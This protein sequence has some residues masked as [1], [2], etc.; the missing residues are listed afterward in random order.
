MEGARGRDT[1]VG[2]EREMVVSMQKKERGWFLTNEGGGG[3]DEGTM[4][5]SKETNKK[6]RSKRKRTGNS[7]E[8][9][10]GELKI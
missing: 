8:Q 5:L 7:K 9:R 10:H 1:R 6:A 2:K 3:Q 4:E